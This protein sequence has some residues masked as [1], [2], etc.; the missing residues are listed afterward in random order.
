MFNR[1]EKIQLCIRKS[2][3]SL[4][5][6]PNAMTCHQNAVPCTHACREKKSKKKERHFP[7]IHPTHLHHCTA[8]LY[9]PNSL[10]RQLTS[11]LTFYLS[12]DHALEEAAAGL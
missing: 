12:L 11:P 6:V 2:S 8:L 7:F 3:N 4:G 10:Q 1:F 9:Q 5:I